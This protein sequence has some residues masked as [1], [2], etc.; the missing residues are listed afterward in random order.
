M[1]RSKLLKL[2]KLPAR[3]MDDLIKYLMES[4]TFAAGTEGGYSVLYDP[5]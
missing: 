5:A 3:E 1:P 2:M 4:G